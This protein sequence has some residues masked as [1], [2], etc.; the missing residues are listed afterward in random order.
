MT[1]DEVVA[2]GR[3]GPRRRAARRDAA[4]LRARATRSPAKAGHHPGRHQGRAR[5]PLDGELVLGDEVLTPDSSR[6]W[7]AETWEPG[8]AQPS[9]DKQYVRDWLTA[10]RLGQDRPR[11]GAAGRGRGADPGEVRRGLRAADRLAAS[12]ATSRGLTLTRLRRAGRRSPRS[13]GWRAACRRSWSPSRAPRRR[14][15]ASSESST[16]RPIRRLSG[17]A[18]PR[19]G[20]ALATAWPCGSRISGLSMTSTTIWCTAT[21]ASLPADPARSRRSRVT[22]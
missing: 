13:P 14:R 22:C 8:R 18:K 17:A 6:F 11:A 3:R 1:F 10:S 21:L 5:A 2:A 9:Y 7:P 15:S 4:G 12:T 20:R 16:C 19:L